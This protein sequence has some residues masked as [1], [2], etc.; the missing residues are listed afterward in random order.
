MWQS[1]RS[2]PSAV[3][4]AESGGGAFTLCQICSYA[5]HCSARKGGCSLAAGGGALPQLQKVH[6][7]MTTGD[8]ADQH[9]NRRS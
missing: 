4:A 5:A 9:I 3:Y 1:K 7:T 6:R 8:S 2:V